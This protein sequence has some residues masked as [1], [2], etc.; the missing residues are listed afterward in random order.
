M[1]LT[2]DRKR[3]SVTRQRSD[4]SS[5]SETW[6]VPPAWRETVR[7]NGF[8]LQKWNPPK[9]SSEQWTL[10]WNDCKI[11]C[12]GKVSERQFCSRTTWDAHLLCQ[13]TEKRVKF[14]SQKELWEKAGEAVLVVRW[15]VCSAAMPG[16]WEVWNDL[17]VLARRSK[18]AAVSAGIVLLIPSAVLPPWLAVRYARRRRRGQ[19]QASSPGWV[20]PAP[21]GQE[22]K[23]RILCQRIKQRQ[24]FRNVR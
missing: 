20:K 11:V 8:Q 17:S 23:P 2:S 1:A 6:V 22:E 15:A 10:F 13:N 7:K 24:K 21:E 14:V 9:S 12:S 18:E 4:P 3:S 19:T 5:G 16:T